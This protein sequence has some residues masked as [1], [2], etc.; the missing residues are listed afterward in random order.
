MG[1]KSLSLIVYDCEVFAYDHLVTLKDKETGRKTHI[2][3]D[4]DKYYGARG[5]RVCDE[6]KTGSK[7]F[8]EWALANGYKEDLTIDRINVDGNYEPSNCRWIT[9]AEQNRNRRF[10][11]IINKGVIEWLGQE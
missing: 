11:R 8:K 1:E 10:G 4:N 6:W 2:W 9:Q 3:N 5:I 7:L